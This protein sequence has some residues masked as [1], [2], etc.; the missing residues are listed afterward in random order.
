MPPGS[1][2]R[3]HVHT[4]TRGRICVTCALKPHTR[5]STPTLTFAQSSNCCAYHFPAEVF[6]GLSS[7]RPLLIRLPG[8]DLKGGLPTQRPRT[9][10][11][12]TSCLQSSPSR[13]GPGMLPSISTEMVSTALTED[14]H[15]THRRRHNTTSP[16]VRC[17]K[18]GYRWSGPARRAAASS[19]CVQ[20]Q[21]DTRS[22]SG[23]MTDRGFLPA[24]VYWWMGEAR[25]EWAGWAYRGVCM[26]HPGDSRPGAFF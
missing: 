18:D 5:E 22:S 25:L 8:Q 23:M 3:L 6:D 16:R 19:Y 2:R 7:Q 15:E 1:L 26:P 24:V 12:L 9:P 17:E 4:C 20:D 10:A 14:R 13:A 11:L 21:R